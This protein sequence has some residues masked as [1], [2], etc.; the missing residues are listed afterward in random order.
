MPVKR[1][2]ASVASLIL[3]ASALRAATPCD[4]VPSRSAMQIVVSSGASLVI[5]AGVTE[6]LKH[7]VHELRPDRSDNGSFPSRHT[8][9]T[10]TASTILSNELYRY[11]LWWSL[12][13]Q[14]AASAMAYQRVASR[15][16]YASD[17]IA[18]AAIGIASTE[19]GYWL[20]RK[21]IGGKSPC[22]TSD[23]VAE[24][25]PNISL[26][27]QAVYNFS[28]ELCTAF[29]TA[30]ELRLP[31]DRH[32]GSLVSLGAMA[33]P[34]KTVTDGV[35]PLNTLSLQ[36]GGAGHFILPCHSLALEP[37][38]SLGAAC[39]A[40]N[41]CEYSRYAFIGALGTG[42]QW[43]LTSNFGMRAD[44]AYQMLTL[45]GIRSSISLRLASVAFF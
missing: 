41:N 21:I 26:S 35:Q 22:S 18:G 6:V 34:V 31:L 27:T 38:L 43:R 45:A 19:L 25:S 15:N 20:G 33:T 9:W 3:I 11:S 28:S 4:T 13:A 16:H 5:N 39:N 36:L 10:F 14:A 12:G 2:L 24:F 42:L 23:V 17:V 7:S 8:S 1:I 40:G 30:V 44:V 37:M 32:W 29:A